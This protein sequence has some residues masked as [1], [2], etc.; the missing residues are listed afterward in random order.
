MKI[1]IDAQTATCNA[2]FLADS[3]GVTTRN[4]SYWVESGLPTLDRGKSGRGHTFK[5]PVAI[6]W[7]LACTMHEDERAARTLAL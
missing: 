3:F 6:H 4:V 7:I 1:E 2:A 5:A